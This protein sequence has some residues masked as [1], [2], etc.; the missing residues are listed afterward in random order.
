[1][2]KPSILSKLPQKERK[3]S[4]EN[5]T[6]IRADR[7]NN[8]INI[9]IGFLNLIFISLHNPGLLIKVTKNAKIDKL[10]IKRK[11]RAFPKIKGKGN[12]GM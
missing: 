12:I 1:M 3:I 6:L 2:I 4:T 8:D 10:I 11:K 5:N 7:T 9:K